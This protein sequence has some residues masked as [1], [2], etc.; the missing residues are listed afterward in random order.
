MKLL[1][2][3]TSPYVRKVLM[4]LHETGLLDRVAIETVASTPLAENPGLTAANPLGRIPC[5]L[6]EDGPAVFDSRV[7]CRYLDSL[8]GGAKFYPEGPSLWTTLTLE[9]LADGMLDSAVSGMYERR[10]RPEAIQFGPWIE[11][12]KGK[13]GRALDAL[14]SQW[15]AHLEGPADAGALATAATLG[16]LDLRYPDMGWREGRPRLA[17]WH[18]RM[19]ERP[20]YAATAPT[21]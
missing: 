3:P 12:Q 11:A 5:L 18:A 8:H 16:Y 21:P 9:A 10:L 4:L 20:S 15:I 13:I 2:S 14:E 7:I 19:A 6:R 17:A 1:H